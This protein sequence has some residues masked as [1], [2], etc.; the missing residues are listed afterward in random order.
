MFVFKGEKGFFLYDCGLILIWIIYSSTCKAPLCFSIFCT[1]KKKVVL[2]V[3]GVLWP[4]YVLAASS[5]C[6]GFLGVL[7]LSR[8][9]LM[10][11]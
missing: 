9:L 1:K 7:I 10:L 6:L 8:Q 11:Y 4:R 5:D 3:A 2:N